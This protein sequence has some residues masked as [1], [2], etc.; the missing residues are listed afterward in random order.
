MDG[1]ALVFLDET[2]TTTSM[3][4]RYGWG[5]RG[6]R[7]VDAAP[8][9]H[10]RSTTFVAGL[11][12][13]GMIAPSRPRRTDDRRGVPGLRR[14]VPGADNLPGRRGRHGQTS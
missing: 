13:D 5:T 2:S 8:H 9:G 6:E 11:R 10:W 1:A 4:R 3:V 14:A 12:H 7:L